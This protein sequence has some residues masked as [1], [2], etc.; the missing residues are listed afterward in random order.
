M[1]G[2]PPSQMTHRQILVV[3]SGLMLG[4]FL[5][6]LD[7]TIVAT[8]LPTIAGDFGQL[9]QLSWVVTAY[10]LTSTAA[11]PLYGKLSDLFGRRRIFQAAIVI[12]LVG[13]TLAGMSQSMLQL[14]AF[15]AIQ[16]VGA[17]GLIVM[18]ITI[19]GD[20]LSPRQR[21]RYQG[22]MGSVFALS[23]VAG[24]LLGGLF[25]DHASWRWVFYVNLP[26]GVVALVVTSSVL[27]LPFQRRQHR[28][29][30][31][32]AAL[33]VAGVTALLLVT[34]WGG[35][36]YAWTSP[37]IAGLTAAAVALLGLFV[38]QE[39]RAAE[40][41]LPLRLFRNRSFAL[42][43]AIGWIVGLAMFGGIV[44]LPVFLQVVTGV[45]ATNSGLL[46][47]PLIGGLLA[48]S[49]S[50]GQIISRTGRYK[51]FPVVGTAVT[52][53]GLFLLSTMGASTS[54]LVAAAYM[55]VLGV[56]IG[57]T[58]QVLVISVQ[59]AVEQRDLGVATSLN[60]FFRSLGGAIGTAIF[61]AIVTAGVSHRV[62]DLVAG[63]AAVDVDRV[64]GSPTAIL[65][66]P[67]AIRV[68]VVEAF[69]DWITT[70]FLVAAPLA[71]VALVLTLALPEL[72]L[73]QVAHVGAASPR[74]D[75]D[76][77]SGSDSEEEVDSGLETT[78]ALAFG[79]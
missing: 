22:Y 17:G 10:L 57:L 11:S 61:G 16:G 21:G 4:M 56:G 25:V 45:E 1:T 34:T 50:S 15:R 23:S 55:L 77:D 19:I 78:E 46:L 68:P 53:L 35:T 44:Y 33:L 9:D 43:S 67:A 31:L 8:A 48:A 63:G 75:S 37:V 74:S 2:G 36:T 30:Y 72:P 54:T 47:V 13:S 12:F 66:L 27:N 20:V 60:L 64:T 24:P 71:V 59:N 7:Q 65:N 73:R 39:R 5:A 58:L 52:A 49:V 40:P 3:F 38:L 42:T 79:S 51:I 29:D 18:A 14:I 76:S 62:G 6:A 41:I 28:V 70:A 26:I 69:A 32:G